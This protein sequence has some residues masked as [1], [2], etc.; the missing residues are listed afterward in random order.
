VLY[1]FIKIEL[2]VSLSVKIS[3]VLSP[4]NVTFPPDATVNLMLETLAEKSIADAV[5]S[6][7]VTLFVVLNA[8]S[9][10]FDSCAELDAMLVPCID[11]NTT[12]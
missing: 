3:P 1:T 8:I 7:N 9:P 10:L 6:P 12:D 5:T 11:F 2:V 4:K